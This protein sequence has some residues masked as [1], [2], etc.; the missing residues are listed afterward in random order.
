DFPVRMF[1]GEERFVHLRLHVVPDDGETL[2][3]VL[4]SWIDITDRVDYEE[5]LKE[6]GETLRRL[7][8]HIEEAREKE[9]TQIAMNLHDD[10]GQKLTALR[11][12]LSWLRKRIGV[13]SPLVIE[14]LDEV[15]GIIESSVSTVQR[16]SSDLRPALLYDL[17]LKDA[18]EWHMKQ[19]LEPA[20]IKGSFRLTPADFK[21]EEKTSIVLFRIIQEALT[22]IIRHSGA[23]V[24]G[25]NITIKPSFIELVIKDNGRG[26]DP[27]AVI[28][29]K[30]FGI[31]GIKERVK[32]ISGDF[33]LTGERGKGTTLTVRIP[34]TKTQ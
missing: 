31:T 3:Q 5:G 18:V 14:K 22:N 1:G 30:S 25:I 16:I 17:G 34:L 24:A 4:V 27:D 13:Q 8:I 6:P 7:N 28:D 33:T 2:S 20:G 21:I 12:N 10:L 19:N 26:V 32:N 23:S 9:R 15:E 11:M 29:P